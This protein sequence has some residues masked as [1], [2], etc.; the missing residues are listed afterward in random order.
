MVLHETG[1]YKRS[2]DKFLAVPSTGLKRYK[3]RTGKGATKKS[4]KPEQL[5]KY[6]NEVGP[7]V[8]GSKQH[9]KQKRGK[10][11]AF[12]LKSKHGHG[13]MIAR[14]VS[15][16]SRKLEIL[17]RFLDTADIDKRW[18]FVKTVRTQVL[19]HLGPEVKKRFRA[20]RLR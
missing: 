18:D 6:Y 10:P 19:M 14:R 20:I 2:H 1:G 11:K 8:K 16:T 5:L 12:I 15:R 17:Y 13:S 3:Y 4:W 7:N 9:G